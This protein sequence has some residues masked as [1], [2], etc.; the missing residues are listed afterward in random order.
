[1]TDESNNLTESKIQLTLEAKASDRRKAPLPQPK[2]ITTFSEKQMNEENDES[3]NLTKS[4]HI[5]LSLEAKSSNRQKAP[6]PQPKV[7]ITFS[8]KQIDD[9]NTETT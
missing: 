4:E 2:E 9:K 7:I 6:L 1:M 8:E 3:N 5:Q